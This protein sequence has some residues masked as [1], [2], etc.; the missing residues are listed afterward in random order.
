MLCMYICI[1]MYMYV[2]IYVYVYICICV[3]A[4]VRVCVCVCVYAR[5]CLARGDCLSLCFGSISGAAA[6]APW[7]LW[8]LTVGYPGS[9]EM[10]CSP[11]SF[12][13]VKGVE[14]EIPDCTYLCVRA[15]VCACVRVRACVCVCA[16]VR[17]CACV[18]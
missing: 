13:P 1:C 11:I 14:R 2:C 9:P 8:V 10:K 7:V 5:A 17:A 12:A 3:C 15:C 4:C 6:E 16:C 18:C